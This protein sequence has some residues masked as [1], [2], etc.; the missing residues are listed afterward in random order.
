MEDDM[1]FEDCNI[2]CWLWRVCVLII[3]LILFWDVKN[4]AHN[5]AS[6]PTIEIVK[7][8]KEIKPLALLKP[9]TADVVYD[10]TLKAKLT[11][12][13]NAFICPFCETHLVVWAS[14]GE[15]AVARYNCPNCGFTTFEAHVNVPDKDAAIAELD[16]LIIKYCTEDGEDNLWD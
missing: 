7:E 4:I 15:T 10:N 5:T 16:R 6:P 14:A 11:K 1:I 3:L 13:K 8:E 9:V 12:N 2:F